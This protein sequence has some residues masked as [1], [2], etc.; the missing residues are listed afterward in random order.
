MVL[1]IFL[2]ILTLFTAIADRYTHVPTP[3]GDVIPFLIQN[4][5]TDEQVLHAKRVLESYLKDLQAVNGA[6]KSNVANAI[7][8]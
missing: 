8:R 6:N 5:F 3:N 1:F 2:K 7:G 4:M